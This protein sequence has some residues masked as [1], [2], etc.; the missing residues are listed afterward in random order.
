MKLL[1]SVSLAVLA[2]LVVEARADWPEQPITLVVPWAA[3]GGTDA[4]A[5]TLA[6]QI[7]KTLGQ[8]VNVVNRTGGSGVVG[9]TE[10]VSAAPDGYTI[11]LATAEFISYYWTGV[12]EFT[13]ENLTPIGLANF[14]AA[15]FS[16]GTDS[17]WKDLGG[18]LTAIGGA[19]AGT[20]K[21]TAPIGGSYHI[22]VSGLLEQQG[23]SPK[24][25]SVVP[26]Q[27]AAPGFQEL[28]SGGVQIAP[29]SLPEAKAMIESG[30]VRA[31]AV[32]ADKRLD[33]YPDVPTAAEATG[34]PYVG[35]TWR[36][37][38]APAGLDATIAG[39]LADAVEK[40]VNSDEYKA[41]LASRGFGWGWMRGE[42]FTSF[43]ATQHENVGKVLTS[44]DMN[45]RK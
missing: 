10:I 8:P 9:H 16:V 36:G 41:F 38:V 3:G 11:G 29:F 5:R 30:H 7:E 39:K 34:K 6:T 43:L 45:Q 25:L 23:V 12:A 26:V 44:L 35:G 20:Y 13:Y 32:L 24:L 27:G 33:A 4:I 37:I 15:A 18:A 40:A 14:D 22:A 2:A 31:L 1:T 19:P 21:M 28:A 42:E 17:P